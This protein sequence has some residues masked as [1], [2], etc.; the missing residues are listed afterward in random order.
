MGLLPAHA[1]LVTNRPFRCPHHT[2]S[3]IALIGGGSIP[4]PGEVTL[5]HNGVLFLD[6]LPE[7][8]RNALESLRQPLEDHHVTVSRAAKTI[9]FPS[10]FMMMASMNPCP[11]GFSTDPRKECHCSPIQIQK[12]MSK[13]SGPLLDRIDIHLEVPALPS[14]DLLSKDTSEP[15]SNIKQ[16]TSQSRSVQHERFKKTRIFCNAQMSQREIKHFCRPCPDGEK[17]L[18]TA[19]EELG[20]SA[21]AHDKIL[22][23]SRTV[24]R[25]ILSTLFFPKHRLNSISYCFSNSCIWS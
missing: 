12:Y 24:I 7:F 18:Q 5:A 19:I 25:G 4:K 21:R 6:E 1:A 10:K 23:V 11:C 16:R 8:S 15:S 22:K 17:L 2:C 3:D 13:I 20:L 14:R 9:R